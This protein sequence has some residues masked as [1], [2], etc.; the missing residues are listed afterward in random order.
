[1]Q[2]KVIVLRTSLSCLPFHKSHPTASTKSLKSHL[3]QTKA[4]PSLLLDYFILHSLR[5]LLVLRSSF[6]T[7]FTHLHSSSR[8]S[9]PTLPTAKMQSKLILSAALFSAIAFAQSNDFN[10]DTAEVF[11]LSNLFSNP[12][13]ALADVLIHRKLKFSKISKASSQRSKRTRPSRQTQPLL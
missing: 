13:G 7:H 9:S 11:V 3:P 10:I 1:M 5:L 12:F 4:F 6:A 8:P 2:N